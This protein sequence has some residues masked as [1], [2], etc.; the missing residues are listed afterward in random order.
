MIQVTVLTLKYMKHLEKYLM[1]THYCTWLGERG[2][3][4]HLSTLALSL[5]NFETFETFNYS[6]ENTV[7]LMNKFVCRC[8]SLLLVMVVIVIMSCCYYFVFV[9]NGGGV[10][11]K[12]EG[13]L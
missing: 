3:A 2:V 1:E 12:C 7:I 13:G 8:L 10:E 9:C 5:K 4:C 6:R 11:R